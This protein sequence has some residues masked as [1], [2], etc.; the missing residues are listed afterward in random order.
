MSLKTKVTLA[1]RNSGRLHNT[2]GTSTGAAHNLEL[3]IEEFQ[4]MFTF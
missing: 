4:S 3:I 1:K 2:T